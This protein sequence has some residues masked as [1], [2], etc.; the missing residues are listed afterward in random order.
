MSAEKS[1]VR[2]E[3]KAGDYDRLDHTERQ[4]LALISRAG[5][6]GDPDLA[7]ELMRDLSQYR[8]LYKAT[9]S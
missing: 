9:E 5:N 2:Q 7:L 4:Y 3:A 1:S 6:A 8:E